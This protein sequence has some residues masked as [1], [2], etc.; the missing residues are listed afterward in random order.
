VM[1][2]EVSVAVNV[3]VPAVVDFVV[4]VA[5]PLPFVVPEIVVIVLV[6]PVDDKVTVLP[7]I[8]LE[9]ASFKVTVIVEVVVPSDAIVVGLAVAV[10]WA[11]VTAPAVK[12]T[13]AADGMT[14]IAS[15]VSVA[16]NVAV[17]AVVEVV[18]NVATPLPFVVP[19]T[20]V[21][22]LVTPEDAS[23]TVLPETGFESASFKITVIVEVVVP[24]AA[25]DIGLAVTVDCDAETPP[26]VT[27]TVGNVLVT[28]P[29]WTDAPIVVAVPASAPVKVAV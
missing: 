22:V 10:E 8:G 19:E 18:V 15:D 4:K 21:I 12:V 29:P 7:E 16:V 1:L 27:E 17:P 3:A 26:T 14:V 2:S 24:S 20:V 23:V 9:L 25:I 11:V 13:V 5:T 6:A 28:A